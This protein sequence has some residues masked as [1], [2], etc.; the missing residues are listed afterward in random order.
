MV[1]HQKLQRPALHKD[2]TELEEGSPRPSRSSSQGLKGWESSAERC[3]Q[4]QKRE[5]PGITFHWP[6]TLRLRRQPKCPRR[7]A[8][9]SDKLDQLCHP[10][11]PPSSPSQPQGKQKKPTQQSSLQ[12]SRPASTKLNTLWRSSKTAMAKVNA[13]IRLMERRR[14]LF[15]WLLTTVL[16][17]LPT[18]LGSS[19]LSP[20][21]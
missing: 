15:S 18:K 1:S 7:G 11:V 14:Q 12:I 10:Q 21:G 8:P 6:K 4:P 19:K 2:S 3:P 17:I 13:L 9:R 20:A 5:D 16:W